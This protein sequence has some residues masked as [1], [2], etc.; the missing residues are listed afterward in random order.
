MKVRIF[1]H[2][3]SLAS[4]WREEQAARSK[5]GGMLGELAWRLLPQAIVERAEGLLLRRENGGL[6]C[7][8]VSVYASIRPARHADDRKTAWLDRGLDQIPGYTVK[9]VEERQRKI[10]CRECEGGEYAGWVDKGIDTKLACDLVAMATA[11][12][13]EAGLLLSD[14]DELAPAIEAVQDVLDRKIIHVGFR[15]RG[16]RLRSA[17]W[18]HILIDDFADEIACEE[19]RDPYD[20]IT[21]A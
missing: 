6:D 12:F 14:D 21:T 15:G 7:R 5:A 19:A 16:D 9:T 10:K 20:A 13:Y 17:C 2:H 8:G 1:V 18:G 11:D 4:T 3:A